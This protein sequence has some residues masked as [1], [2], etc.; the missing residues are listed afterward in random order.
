MSP[1]KVNEYQQPDLAENRIDFYYRKKNK[2]VHD[3]LSFLKK[4]SQ[5][6]LGKAENSEM[7]FSLD[8]VFYF[9]SVDKKTFA[10]LEKKILQMDARLQDLEDA[11]F[12]S[13]F[14]RVNKSTVLNVFRI[15]TIKPELN[16]RVIAVLDNGERI[17]INRSYKRKFNLFLN[18]MTKGG[19]SSED[20]Q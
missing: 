4:H 20:H 1:L 3:I 12:E 11:Y 15:H 8:E 2:E 5:R 6:L 13:G 14:V 18:T 9:E 17:Q 7:I 16:M 19:R 10:C